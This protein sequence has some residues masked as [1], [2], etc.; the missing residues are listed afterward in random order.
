M[1]IVWGT[2]IQRRKKG[3][4]LA[5]CPICRDI[6]ACATKA[7][8]KTSH[9]YYLPTGRPEQLYF[10]LKCPSC[11]SMLTRNLGT[12]TP[13]RQPIDNP[14]AALSQLLPDEYAPICARLEIE[15]KLSD[16]TPEQRRALIAEPIMA[17][18]YEHDM[19]SKSGWRQSV[20]SLSQ[21]G[22][23]VLG[24]ATLVCWAVWSADKKPGMLAWSIGVS[25]LTA[26]ALAAVVWL[27]STAGKRLAK[28]RF[29]PRIADSLRPIAP[30]REELETTVAALASRG[31]KLAT[32]L[33]A[34]DL[35]FAIERP[36]EQRLAA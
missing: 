9:V 27:A 24:V 18:N 5:F 13:H 3:Y 2:K 11:G 34:M 31:F 15:G 29:V 30:T 26:C 20:L 6:R 8:E 1:F 32:S 35:Q 21:L 7:V 25:S 33:S 19:N 23:V 22:L 28:A 36:G 14:E 17:L 16:V 4:G 12:I 10:E